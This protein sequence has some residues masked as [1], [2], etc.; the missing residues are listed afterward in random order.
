LADPVKPYTTE[1]FEQ[2]VE[3]LRAFATALGAA[4]TA[5]VTAARTKAGLRTAQPR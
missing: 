2:A 5:K 1:Q 3:D 4:V